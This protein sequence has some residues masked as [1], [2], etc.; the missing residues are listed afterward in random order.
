MRGLEAI[1]HLRS[2]L[3]HSSPEVVQAATEAMRNI[4]SVD[5]RPDSRELLNRLE[6]SNPNTVWNAIGSLGSLRDPTHIPRLATFLRHDNLLIRRSAI[7]AL[8]QIGT[9]EAWEALVPS[10][11]GPEGR[12]VATLYLKSIEART[13]HQRR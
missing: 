6:D 10:W 13:C 2:L 5:A 9:P 11:G 1:P 7:V 4:Q 3:N 8:A 12:L